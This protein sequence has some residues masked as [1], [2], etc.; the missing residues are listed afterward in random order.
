MRHSLSIGLC[1]D[2]H[3]HKCAG[4]KV[5]ILKRMRMCV[6]PLDRRAQ[7]AC[8]TRSMNACTVDSKP[9][10]SVLKCL[11]IRAIKVTSVGMDIV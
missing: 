10:T 9:H 5:A 6:S 1:I 11:C 8:R 7:D 3:L 4:I 2:T